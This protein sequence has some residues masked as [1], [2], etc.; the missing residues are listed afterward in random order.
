MSQLSIVKLEDHPQ[1]LDIVAGWIDREWG[2]FSGRSLQ[3]TRQRFARE[4]AGEG[5]PT[6]YVALDGTAVVG[7]ATLREHDSVRWDEQAT[8]WVCNVYVPPEARGKSVAKQLCLALEAHARQLGYTKIF[9]A[10]LMAADSLYHRMGYVRYR[11]HDAL[12]YPMY[13]M[14]RELVP[15]TGGDTVA[16]VGAGTIGSAWAALFASRGLRVNVYDPCSAAEVV[17]HE[18]ATQ[19]ARALGQSH[20]ELL[21][22]FRFTTDLDQALH[23]ACFVQESGPESLP[24]KQRLHADMDRR[25]PPSVVI[26]S[27]TSDLP[28]SEIQKDCLHPQRT[29]VA[30]PINPPYAVPLVE[31]VGGGKTTE[32]TLERA[33][34]FYR[35]LGRM[36]V[37]LDGEAP[38]FVA[39]RLQMA[40]L[41]EAL[42]MVARGQATIAQVDHVLMHGIGLRWAAVGMFGAYLLNLPSR[43]VDAW[44][45]HLEQFDFGAS[46]VHTGPFP[47]W[48][49]R[50]RQSIAE[51]WRARVEPTGADVLLHERDSIAIELTRRRTPA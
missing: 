4:P 21:Q 22:R 35:A 38:G 10:T 33:C 36:P 34:A 23:Q 11:V 25:L 2:R 40:L 42:Q 18:M 12:G 29:V 32:E 24:L 8:P 28:I 49:P 15:V 43:D 47:E 17:L 19:A 30:H 27:S 14:T 46:L 5:L 16:C 9:L 39:N 13:L 50:L 48:S 41:R 45:D 6:S 51:Q 26:A 20:E 1:A 3:E 7:V 31:V 44:L 37:R